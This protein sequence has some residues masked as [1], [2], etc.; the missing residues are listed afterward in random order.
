MEEREKTQMDEM[1][2]AATPPVIL[3]VEDDF[4]IAANVES[5]L[6]SAGF[7][8]CGVA[9]SA[10]QAVSLAKAHH[11]SLAIMDIRLVGQRDG[12]DAA[13]ELR[14]ELGLRCIF[15]SA[16]ADEDTKRRAE[17]AQPLGWLAKPYAMSS[18]IQLVAKSLILLRNDQVDGSV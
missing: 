17:P 4:L 10:D 1:P 13:L 16:H 6:T 14:R 15:A 11:P 5:T 2:T 9:A 18:L 12:I 7:N 3:V 8:V